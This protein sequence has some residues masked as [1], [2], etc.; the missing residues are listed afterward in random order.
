[1]NNRS[2]IVV[3]AVVVAC[4]LALLAALFAAVGGG[5]GLFSRPVLR[6]TVDFADVTGIGRSSDVVYGGDRIGRVDRIEHLGSDQRLRPD[7]AVRAHVAVTRD[8]PISSNLRA[9][10]ASSSILGEPHLALLPLDGGGEV[11]VEGA[12]LTGSPGGGLLDQVLPDGD[13]LVAD[14]RDIVAALRSV[15]TPLLKDDAGRKIAATLANLEQFTSELNRIMEGSEGEP[16]A[17]AQVTGAVQKL[18]RAAGG[19]QDIVLGPEGQESRGLSARADA[20]LVN[21]ENASREVNL[22]LAGAPGQPGLRQR[23]D[24]ITTELQ[25]LLV[26]SP[27]GKG[28]GLSRRLDDL[29][30]KTTTLVEELNVLTV[31]G[32]IFTGTVA[33][34]PNR[35]IFGGRSGEVPTKEEILENLRG[36]RQPF[37]VALPGGRSPGPVREGAAAPARTP[38]P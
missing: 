23:L 20:T 14:L 28:P 37:P 3:A 7:L 31:W 27:G 26:G 38:A 30:A 8:I 22:L 11:L 5:S 4:S 9:S 29:V 32:G 34:R 36:T 13:A 24:E 1:M 6:F 18:D 15:T 17:G 35:V 33:S 25:K 19:L 16:G 10:I 2:D 12:Q 21:I